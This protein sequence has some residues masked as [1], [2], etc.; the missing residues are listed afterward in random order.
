MGLRA[1]CFL[2]ARRISEPEGSLV[3]VIKAAKEVRR[4]SSAH[5]LH[6]LVFFPRRLLRKP[7][8]I[9]ATRISSVIRHARCEPRILRH[10]LISGHAPEGRVVTL[11]L[12]TLEILDG[13]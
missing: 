13:M 1:I 2:L 11:F 3:Q 7:R 6:E 12:C 10:L 9:V 8:H 4:Q 5:A